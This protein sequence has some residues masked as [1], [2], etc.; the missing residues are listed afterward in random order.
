ME[1][2]KEVILCGL[3]M[4]GREGEDIWRHVVGERELESNV[5]SLEWRI[6]D[7][8]GRG[9]PREHL[10]TVTPLFQHT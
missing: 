6:G 9:V 10:I 4:K 3:G 8:L 1:M 2:P 5:A 7:Y